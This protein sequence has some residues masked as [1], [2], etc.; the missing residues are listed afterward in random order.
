MFVIEFKQM[1][2]KEQLTAV[3]GGMWGKRNISDG[4]III[5]PPIPINEDRIPVKEPRIIN[6]IIIIIFY[7]L[8]V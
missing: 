7:R 1:I 5:P 8:L 6:W 4:T 2:A 3:C